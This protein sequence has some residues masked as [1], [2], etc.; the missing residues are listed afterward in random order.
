[1][2]KNPF[3]HQ[4]VSRFIEEY[5]RR[6]HVN[7]QPCRMNGSELLKIMK[8]NDFEAVMQ[9]MKENEAICRKFLDIE[10]SILNIASLRDFFDILLTGVSN[11]F[12]IPYVWLT[13]IEGTSLADLI[14]SQEE[15][16]VIWPKVNFISAGDYKKFT[17]NS[18]KPVLANKYLTPY[19][20]FF[21]QDRDLP[22]RSLA[23]APVYVDGQ[24]AGSLNLG[25]YTS[26]RFHPDM[27]T[28]L[29]EQLMVKISL[30][31]SNVCAHERLHFFASHDALTG[32][33]NR[34]AFENALH[35][36]FSRSRRHNSDLTL[37]F[38]D[39]DGFKQ[40]NDRYGHEC[41]DAVLKY[42]GRNLEAS[43]RREDIP[44]RFAG[45]EFVLIL[46]ETRS[47]A[48]ESMM[49]RIQRHL[50]ENPLIYKGVKLSISLTYGIASMDE[51][52]V[53]RPDQ[54][55]KFADDR[56]YVS[57]GTKIKDVSIPLHP[58]VVQAKAS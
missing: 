11:T 51:K 25:D 35:R 29:L 40:I 8:M 12:D 19:A 53:L 55:L 5:E 2:Q 18:G 49:D 34:G 16:D 4:I 13:A 45:D 23:I 15:A 37:V 33:L 52:G 36:E 41:G 17:K 28:S 58:R 20:V 22:M 47:E 9:H 43:S 21:P 42:V 31:L 54:L 48:S 50:D 1:M 6:K 39:I 26:T 7:G 32:L 27:D 3:P 46:P 44:A 56:L 14:K 38:I 30:C 10:S 57:K 24:L